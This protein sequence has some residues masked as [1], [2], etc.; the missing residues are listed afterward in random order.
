MAI[1][2]GLRYWESGVYIF[3]AVGGDRRLQRIC[4]MYLFTLSLMMFDAQAMFSCAILIV[5]HGFGNVTNEEIYLS[6]TG[7]A[8]AILWLFVGCVAVFHIASL[9]RN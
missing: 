1:K 2:I 5:N 4:R 3:K 7:A 6:V 9:N 8:F